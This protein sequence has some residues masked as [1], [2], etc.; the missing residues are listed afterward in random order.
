M[1]NG[2]SARGFV[3]YITLV[4]SIKTVCLSKDKYFNPNVLDIF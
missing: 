2:S 4:D 3:N 1:A